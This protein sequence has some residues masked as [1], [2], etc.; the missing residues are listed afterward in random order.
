MIDISTNS[1]QNMIQI[2]GIESTKG[3]LGPPV[4]LRKLITREILAPNS[5]TWPQIVNP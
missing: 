2:I 3:T 1:T 4:L 5:P